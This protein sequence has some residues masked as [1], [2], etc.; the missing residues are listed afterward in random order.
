MN[1]CKVSVIIA[2]YNT[3]DYLEECLDSI[4]AQTLSD[5]EVVMID[6]GSTDNTEAIIRKYKEKHGNLVTRYQENRGAGNARNYGISIARGEYMIFMDPDDKYPN[7]DCLEKMYQTAKEY[8]AMIC[9]GNVLTNDHG[10]I[11]DRYHA[12]DGVISGVKN[13]IVHVKDYF[14]LYSHQR[15]LLETRFVKSNQIL[16]ANYQRYEDQVFT[17]KALGVAGWFYEL[18]YP[19]FEHRINHKELNMDYD[20]FLDVLKGFRDTINLICDYDMQL[21]FEKNYVTFIK[22]YMSKIS[23]YV[24]HGNE[25]FNQVLEDINGLVKHSS[26]YDEKYLVT[27]ESIINHMKN[28]RMEKEKLERILE[29]GRPLIIYGAGSNTRK[30]MSIYEFRIKNVIGIAISGERGDLFEIK[31]VKVRNIKDYTPYKAEA[32][33]LITPGIRLKDEII[34]K[35]IGLHF[36]DYEWIDMELFDT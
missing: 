14:Y 16:Y 30:L 35:L 26:W 22:M 25:E 6:D 27:Y 7:E 15:Y 13:Q 4:F 34:E 3:A 21:M 2:T 9:G 10:I 33:V 19:V 28:R 32:I 12:G 23:Q 31:G 24:F 5:I 8:N 11:K 1:T 36:V 29:C 18:D 17:I 20:M